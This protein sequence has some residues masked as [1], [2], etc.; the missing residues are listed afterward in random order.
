MKLYAECK[1]P[2]ARA[3][4]AVAVVVALILLGCSNID[5]GRAQAV[6][7]HLARTKDIQLSEG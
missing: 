7:D 4:P 3:P 1:Y 5:L 2:S 6:D